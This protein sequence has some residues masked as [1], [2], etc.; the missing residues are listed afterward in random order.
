MS[1]LEIFVSNDRRTVK[2]VEFIRNSKG[3]VYK[4][5]VTSLD[6]R[7]CYEVFGRKEI[8]AAYK[9]ICDLELFY[10]VQQKED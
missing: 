10:H 4:G 5:K 9:N 1:D 3:L 2:L 7:Q 6:I 8:E